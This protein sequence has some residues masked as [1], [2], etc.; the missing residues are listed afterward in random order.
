MVELERSL[1]LDRHGSTREALAA[2]TTVIPFEREKASAGVGSGRIGILLVNLGTPD[3]A[4]A[5]GVRVYLK[6]FLSDPRVIENQGLL[7]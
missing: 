2:M 5:A 6:E 7:W 4:N 1:H 3:I